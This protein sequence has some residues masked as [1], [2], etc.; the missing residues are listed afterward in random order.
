M[1]SPK[2]TLISRKQKLTSH[3]DSDKFDHLSAGIICQMY[4]AYKYDIFL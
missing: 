1:N 4:T 3:Y 2:Y